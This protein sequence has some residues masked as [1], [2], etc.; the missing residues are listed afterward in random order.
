MFQI[1]GLRSQKD[2][3]LRK[4]RRIPARGQVLVRVGDLVHAE[5]IVAKGT[6][7]NRDI[8][9]VKIYDEL[10]V[11]P[12]ETEKYLLK[13]EGD[14][15]KKDEVIAIHRFFFGRHTR[16]C[17]SPIDG[18]I[19]LLSKSSGRALI[20]GRPIPVEVKAYVPGRVADTIP[21]EGAV[22]E[23]RASAI[24]G[25][26]GIGGEAVGELVMAV[27][28]PDEALPMELISEGHR[29]K[30]IVGGSFVTVDALRRAV[31]VGLHGII[32]GSMDQKDLIDFLGYEMGL[33]ITG[34]EN[35]GL[36][37]ILTEG[38]GRYSMEKEVFNL[39][40]S[41]QGKQVSINGST[42]IRTRMLRPEIIMPE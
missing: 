6:V 19:E 21:D 2:V 26:F 8:R 13:S 14:E 24:Q 15:V 29:A 18:T 4:T 39:L 35:A 9:E 42:Q 5:T 11:D 1:N 27:N 7:F 10:D 41:H 25:A 20:R 30:V 32:S 3:L 17:R 37:L 38:F 28:E 33:G 31:R 34:R 36:T 22:I 12:T 40:K 23:C 16:V